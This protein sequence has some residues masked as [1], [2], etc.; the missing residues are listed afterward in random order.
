MATKKGEF[1]SANVDKDTVSTIVTSTGKRKTILFQHW[2]CESLSFCLGKIVRS[3]D[4]PLKESKKRKIIPEESFED[5]P[6]E[7]VNQ[8][9]NVIDDPNYMSGTEVRM[10]FVLNIDNTGSIY[11]VWQAL[12]SQRI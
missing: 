5:I 10:I 7:T 12:L 3:S 6:L 8:I 4:G 11:T 9:L 2:K 1:T